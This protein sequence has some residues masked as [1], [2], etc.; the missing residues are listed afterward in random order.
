MNT[1]KM[2]MKSPR[3]LRHFLYNRHWYW[4]PFRLLRRLFRVNHPLPLAVRMISWPA[5][6]VS[7]FVTNCLF[8]IDWRFDHV[9][10]QFDDADI[11]VT[12]N[13]LLRTSKPAPKTSALHFLASEFLNDQQSVKGLVVFRWWTEYINH[14]WSNRRQRQS[15]GHLHALP[16][17]NKGFVCLH[18]FAS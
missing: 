11:S 16:S 15:R 3:I 4:R 1:M 18:V 14:P 5:V 9:H 6:A 8:A 12:R 7:N 2:L 10:K 17:I 13:K